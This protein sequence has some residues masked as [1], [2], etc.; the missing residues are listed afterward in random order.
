MKVAYCLTGLVDSEPLTTHGLNELQSQQHIDFFCHT[1]RDD[2]NPGEDIINNFDFV[3]TS[4]S[5]YAEYED[6]IMSLPEADELYELS[7]SAKEKRHFFRTHLAQFYSTIECVN[8]AIAYDDY[9]II[10]KA[11][12]NIR[13]EKGMCNQFND[14]LV[15]DIQ[16]ILERDP[17]AW[18]HFQRPRADDRPNTKWEQWPSCTNDIQVVFA[19]SFTFPIW[20][21]QAPFLD[22][23]FAMENKFAKKHILHTNFLSNIMN[24]FIDFATNEDSLVMEADKV[25]FKYL[26]DNR[27]AIFGFPMA[28]WMTREKKI[29]I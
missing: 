10:I 2:K 13:F 17:S 1:W 21:Y 15:N 11:R 5:T 25:W 27:I 8:M 16:P 3:R 20:N 6:H 19:P 23:I 28:T 9:D 4:T 24:T 29:I 22:T 14:N 12:S 7:G 18:N 26:M